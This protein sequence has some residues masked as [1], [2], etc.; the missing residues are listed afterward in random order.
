ML[1]I[2]I[3]GCFADFNKACIQHTGSPY[4][5]DCWST[6]DRVPNLFSTLEVIPYSWMIIS[7]LEARNIK[8]ELLGA[9]PLLTEKLVTAQRDKVQWVR[10]RLDIDVQVN[11]VASRH[12]KKYFCKNEDILIDDLP[13]NI[14]QWEEV[15]GIGILHTN[16]DDTI[17]RLKEIYK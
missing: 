9:L 15:G 8:Y 14:K 16:W 3:D 1:Y 10:D 7:F 17:E 6:L 4:R 11:L 13:D 12:Y 5:K 2:D